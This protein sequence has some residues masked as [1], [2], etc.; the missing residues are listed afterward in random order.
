MPAASVIQRLLPDGVRVDT[1]DGAQRER[2][3]LN[4]SEPHTGHARGR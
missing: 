3:N 1:F 4:A 2:P